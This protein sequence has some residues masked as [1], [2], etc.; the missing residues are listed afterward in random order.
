MSESEGLAHCS[1][2]DALRQTKPGPEQLEQ[3]MYD[4][5]AGASGFCQVQ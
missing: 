2:E 3:G 4:C 5:L 1:H